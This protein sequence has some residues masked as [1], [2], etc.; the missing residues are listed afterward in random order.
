M[1]ILKLYKHLKKIYRHEKVK[2]NYKQLNLVVWI[3]A[4]IKILITTL[5][6]KKF[7]QKFVLKVVQ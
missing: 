3:Y 2:V 5:V 6:V 4:H 7:R 1:F